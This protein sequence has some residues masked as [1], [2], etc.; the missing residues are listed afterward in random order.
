M[1]TFSPFGMHLFWVPSLLLVVNAKRLNCQP[2]SNTSI[3][4]PW[5]ETARIDANKLHSVYSVPKNIALTSS[6]WEELLKDITLPKYQQEL[7]NSWARCPGYEHDSIPYHT[8]YVCMVDLFVHSKDC[9]KDIEIQPLCR[10][11]CDSFEDSIYQFITDEASCPFYFKS[12]KMKEISARRESILEGAQHCSALYESPIFQ[13]KQS[14]VAGVDN[15]VKSC[16]S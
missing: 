16:G 1:S 8:T 2:I 7:W 12:S 5:S 4:S 13:S 6:L 11:N 14:C 3:C 9:N 15:D 10:S